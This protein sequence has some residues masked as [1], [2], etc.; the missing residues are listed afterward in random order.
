MHFGEDVFKLAFGDRSLSV[1]AN[2]IRVNGLRHGVVI[3]E[4]GNIF[5]GG[6]AEYVFCKNASSI[7]VRST[8]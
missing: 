8:Q 5:L 3:A 1:D 4:S 2:G 7:E 6:D